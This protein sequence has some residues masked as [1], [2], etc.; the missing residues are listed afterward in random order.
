MP[1]KRNGKNP[2]TPTPTTVPM[3]AAV[4][5]APISEPSTPT[6][7][8]QE[9]PSPTVSAKNTPLPTPE[10]TTD[11]DVSTPTTV[12]TVTDVPVESLKLT[13]K[14]VYT[15]VTFNGLSRLEL[16][17]STKG[18]LLDLDGDVKKKFIIPRFL[19]YTP[20]KKLYNEIVNKNIFHIKEKEVFMKN[21]ILLCLLL[22]PL[23][24]SCGKVAYA[25]EPA[26]NKANGFAL[27]LSSSSI[28]FCDLPENWEY[29]IYPEYSKSFYEYEGEMDASIGAY[30]YYSETDPDAC[31]TIAQASASQRKPF[32]GIG[33]E[34]EHF[35][36]ADG[37][38][39][40]RKLL[41]GENYY[42]EYIYCL[43]SKYYVTLNTSKQDYLEHEEELRAFL[44]SIAF[45]R[46]GISK[47]AS[48]DP[49]KTYQLHI[50]N[51]FLQAELTVRPGTLI[52]SIW[53]WEDT[54]CFFRH[55]S[56]CP[57]NGETKLLLEPA[58]PLTAIVEDSRTWERCK[59]TSGLVTYRTDFE[60]NGQNGTEYQ[61]VRSG[62]RI[63]IYG[64]TTKQVGFI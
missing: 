20:T 52:Q 26:E 6:I 55:L 3:D 36:F 1:P 25:N 5:F 8:P 46:Y 9:Y 15:P 29:R 54:N 45:G 4:F 14:I 31:I 62:C 24:V 42:K 18:L 32:E 33:G 40:M 47:I 10:S 16:T 37:S 39:G 57:E 56:L 50:W 63:K 53:E 59:L 13:A 41:D 27:V 60:E 61:L 48:E 28:F 11:V 19:L 44:D 58:D 23:L 43:Y 34:A 22:F 2:E 30:F 49:D 21:R 51:E 7:P 35:S 17:D 38:I 64:E 12:P